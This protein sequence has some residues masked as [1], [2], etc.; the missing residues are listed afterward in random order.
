MST[1]HATGGQR[2]ADMTVEVGAVP[3]PGLLRPAI[4]AAIAGQ[5]WPA[6]PEA[7]VAQAVAAR[8]AA[9]LRHGA[10]PW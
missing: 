4:E 7:S 9:A 3:E 8:V 1:E 10:E 2:G 5:S 6:G